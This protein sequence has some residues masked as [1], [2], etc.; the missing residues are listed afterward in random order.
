MSQTTSNTFNSLLKLTQ[1]K[2][3]KPCISGPLWGESNGGPWTFTDKGPRRERFHVIE[4]WRCETKIIELR[5][6]P[7]QR[8][9]YQVT[10]QLP[11]SM[12]GAWLDWPSVSLSQ[13]VTRSLARSLAHPPTRSI[14]RLIDQ[15]INQA[16]E[17]SINQSKPYNHIST[18]LMFV[19]ENG[20]NV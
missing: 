11:E 10:H 2:T 6:S 20:I 13:S 19:S 4:L 14:D 3:S 17:R 15:S 1:K 12:I 5:C 8:L 7:T 18:N 16:I 9:M